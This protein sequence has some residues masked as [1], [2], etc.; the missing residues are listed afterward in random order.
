MTGECQSM[1]RTRAIRVYVCSRTRHADLWRFAR[2]AGAPIISSWID[3]AGVGETDELGELWVRI[4]REIASATH[5][6][7]FAEAGDFPLKGALI[8]AGMALAANKPIRLVLG[9]DV[10]IE[11]RSCRPIGSWI[12]HPLVGRFGSLEDALKIRIF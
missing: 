1:A 9:R 5:V 10:V 11:P 3:E 7:V 12:N 4:H 8:E 2:A 6:I